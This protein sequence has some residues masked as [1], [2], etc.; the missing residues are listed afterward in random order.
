MNTDS[1]ARGSI[2]GLVTDSSGNPLSA[3]K[4][5]TTEAATFSDVYGKWVLTSLT[6]QLT[7]ITAAREN[8][9]SQ[10]QNI[11]VVSG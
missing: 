8:Y 7:E 2:T 11:E 10:R 4:V 5:Y 1:P 9:Q 6:P 3:V